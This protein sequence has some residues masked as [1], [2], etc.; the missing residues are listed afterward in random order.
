MI[1]V[2]V[3]L[4]SA[5]PYGQSKG[6]M[7]E[8]LNKES[9][10]DYEKRTWR[11]RC[12]CDD[13]GQ[14]F[15]PPGALRGTIQDAAK[16]LSMRIPGKGK[17]TYTKH[18]NSGIDVHDGLYLGVHKDKIPG[19]WLFVPSDGKPGGSKRVWK[20]FPHVLAWEGWAT[21]YV[22]DETITKDVFLETLTE[23]GKFI[24]MGFFRPA[25][26]GFW[27]RFSVEEI[28]WDVKI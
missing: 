16:Y 22:L 6:Y 14:V 12:H 8:K 1:K 10:A 17:A 18:F 9:A 19:Q 26:K 21:F 7:E 28:K 2:Q 15:I 25:R 23:A 11:E 5:G 13:K 24:G 27:G 4:K 3:K 20:C